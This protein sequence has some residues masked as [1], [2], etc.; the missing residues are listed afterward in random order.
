MSIVAIQAH[1]P[2]SAI[3]YT[4]YLRLNGPQIVELHLR[5]RDSGAT[6]AFTRSHP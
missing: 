2:P 6:T 5:I 3:V 1:I 4:Y